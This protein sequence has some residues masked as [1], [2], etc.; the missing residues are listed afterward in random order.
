MN[1]KGLVDL[2]FTS[3]LALAFAAALARDPAIGDHGQVTNTSRSSIRASWSGWFAT[4]RDAFATSTRRRRRVT[5]C[6]SAA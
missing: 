1:N 3:I 4:P 5:S 6:C 2:S